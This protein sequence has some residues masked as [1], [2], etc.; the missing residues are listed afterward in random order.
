MCVAAQVLV[1]GRRN[2]SRNASRLAAGSQ[3]IFIRL[4]NLRLLSEQSLTP[5]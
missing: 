5:Q 4:G 3:I 2:G 1:R